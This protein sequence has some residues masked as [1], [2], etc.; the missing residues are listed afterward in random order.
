MSPNRPGR[1]RV[2]KAV[3]WVT[4]GAAGIAARAAARHVWRRAGD[5]EPPANP[6]VSEVRWRDALTWSVGLG[7][8]VGLFR[9]LAR[10]GAASAWYRVTGNEPPA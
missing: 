9:L 7:A 3:A 10:R 8:A 2:W 4:A 5:T 1:D 6:V